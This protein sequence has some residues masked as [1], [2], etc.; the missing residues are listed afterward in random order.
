MASYASLVMVHSLIDGAVSSMNYE[1]RR[2][3]PLPLT[4]SGGIVALDMRKTLANNEEEAITAFMVNH[5]R[6]WSEIVDPDR[7]S[8][9]GT[10]EWRT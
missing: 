8:R 5:H 3:K 4:W 6:L 9:A 1:R 7:C 2:C 10:C